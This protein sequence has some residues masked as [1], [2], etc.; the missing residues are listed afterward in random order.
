MYLYILLARSKWAGALGEREAGGA[1]ETH[2]QVVVK[3]GGQLLVARDERVGDHER[4]GRVRLRER[5]RARLELRDELAVWG[6]R[7]G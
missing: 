6:V 7:T 5:E 2:A 4:E 1:G 3:L